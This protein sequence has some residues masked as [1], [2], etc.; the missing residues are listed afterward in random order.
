MPYTG[1]ASAY[2][3]IGKVIA[4]YFD[5]VNAEAASGAANQLHFL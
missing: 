5:K 4:A 3:V 2:G 1:P